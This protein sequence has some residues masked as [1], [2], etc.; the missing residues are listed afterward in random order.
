MNTRV[1]TTC[2]VAAYRELRLAALREHP[3]AFATDLAEEQALPLEECQKRLEEGAP[4][5]TFG[6]FDGERLVGIGT[7]LRN[8]RVRQRFRATIVGMYVTPAWRRR[9]VARELLN[10]CV[11]RARTLPEIEEVCLCITVGND[12]ARRVYVEFGFQPEFFE[13][14]SFKH[15]GSYYDLEWMRLPLQ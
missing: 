13:P 5:M 9:G 7:L 10:A 2:D 1:L 8:T 14:R 6:A 4:G 15:E 3:T 12:A 11:E